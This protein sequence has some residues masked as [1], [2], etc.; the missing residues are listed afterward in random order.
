MVT[1]LF[2]FFILS[3][4]GFI[5]Y[6]FGTVN[7]LKAAPP[8]EY[9]TYRFGKLHDGHSQGVLRV[10]LSDTHYGAEE[11]EGTDRLRHKYDGLGDLRLAV[12][13]GASLIK[14][15]RLDLGGGK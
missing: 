2:N 3:P 6:V 10:F 8:Q 15:N 9:K 11:I 4:E 7:P 5:T 13:Q 12:S 14:D 1:F